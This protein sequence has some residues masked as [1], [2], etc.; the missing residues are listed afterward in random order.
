MAISYE[1]EDSFVFFCG[2]FFLLFFCWEV[3]A[4]P[5]SSLE[6]HFLL[7]RM[8]SHAEGRRSPGLT[9]VMGRCLLAVV[10]KMAEGKSTLYAVTNQASDLMKT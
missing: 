4:F 9:V 6:C 1:V 5:I 7:P 8:P 10:L 2:G 3:K